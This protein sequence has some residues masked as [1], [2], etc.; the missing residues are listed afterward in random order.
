MQTWTMLAQKGGVGKSM[1]GVGL[2]VETAARRGVACVADIDPQG[3]AISWSDE[4]KQE[5]DPIVTATQANRLEIVQA[6]CKKSK[7]MR[8]I[9]DTSAGA[10][11]GTLEAA[12]IADLI[13]IPCQPA[14]PDLSA[15]K[16]TATF[17]QMA[18]R[19]AIFVLNRGTTSGN[20]R[21]AECREFLTT[22]GAKYGIG[23]CPIEIMNRMAHVK[24]YEVGKTAREFEPRSKAAQEMEAL[25]NWI[26][27]HHG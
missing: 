12:K 24:A 19:P 13:I 15:M 16:M 25:E 22:L 20:N 23:V 21:I 6:A 9:I 14:G 18:D 26:T 8:L 27:K 4:R 1:L 2:A 11:A 10:S 7:V 3:T 5:S 17:V